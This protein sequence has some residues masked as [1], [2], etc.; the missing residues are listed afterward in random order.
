MTLNFG[1]NDPSF[2][3][4]YIIFVA[5]FYFLG[6]RGLLI[7]GSSVICWSV[8]IYVAEFLGYGQFADAPPPATI[9]NLSL[10]IILVLL[11]LLLLYLTL[12]QLVRANEQLRLAKE[13][14][15]VANRVKSSFLAMMSH[16]LRTPLNSILGFSDVI[17]EELND[18][19]H[20]AVPDEDIDL[21]Q[22]DL[23]HIQRAGR[24]LLRI[25]N[26]VL[27]VSK[28]EAMADSVVFEVVNVAMICQEVADLVQFQVAEN[29]N[30]LQVNAPAPEVIVYADA[31]KIRLILTNLL[32][33]GAKF[34]ADGLIELTAVIESD[35][36][37][38]T[39]QL[40][41]TVSDTGVGIEA[42]QQ[43]HVFEPF[44]QADSTVARSADGSGL[45][46]TIC[47][48]MVTLMGGTIELVSQACEGARF[49]IYLPVRSG[50]DEDEAFVL[51]E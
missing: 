8:A 21:L 31:Q 6:Y 28:A 1:L 14:A 2:Q 39:A 25:I 32:Q 23:D 19:R 40:H 46:L 51:G 30:R 22:T 3:A 48:R 17:R 7:F 38:Q 15:E 43:E 37:D 34:T 10:T 35:E 50:P 47:Q 49:D 26:D 27:E 16:E 36:D 20:K 18:F 11:S 24:N 9:E 45:G 5:A 33:N 41:L 12:Q 29:R 4:V 42:A 44:Y 13:E